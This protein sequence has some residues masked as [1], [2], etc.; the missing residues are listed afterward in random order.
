MKELSTEVINING[1]DYTLFLN[2]TGIVAWEKYTE[3]EEA[4]MVELQNKY[5]NVLSQSN[6]KNFEE[7]EDNANPFEGLDGLDDM[8]SDIDYLRKIYGR[9]YWIMLYTNHKLSISEATKLYEDATKEYGDEQVITL[10]RQMI[11]TV[12]KNPIQN[13]N[14][15]NL[16]ALKPK[17]N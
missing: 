4:K 16:T 2:R 7:L 1:V 6:S 12:N 14:L 9:L 13:E 5:K 3:N 15:K 8:E 10:A 11:E 17:K